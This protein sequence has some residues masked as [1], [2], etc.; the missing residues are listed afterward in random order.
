MCLYCLRALS[1]YYWYVRLM[2]C[3]LS[4]WSHSNRGVF[5]LKWKLSYW[6]VIVDDPLS[7]VASLIAVNGVRFTL[8]STTFVSV[9]DNVPSKR[10]VHIFWNWHSYCCFIVCVLGRVPKCCDCVTSAT[11]L[12]SCMTRDLFNNILIHFFFNTVKCN[13]YECTLKKVYLVT[14]H[15]GMNR[16]NI[17]ISWLSL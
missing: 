11:I 16:I 15:D 6:M 10:I 17:F 2:M 14:S 8:L 7:M 3:S 5:V 12:N 1:C 9:A 13:I 4:S